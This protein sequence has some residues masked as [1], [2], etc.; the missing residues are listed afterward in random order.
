MTRCLRW[1][2]HCHRVP[3][4]T[5]PPPTYA[6]EQI[7]QTRSSTRDAGQR[8]PH[9]AD[10]TH[11]NREEKK[12]IRR[13]LRSTSEELWSNQQQK[14]PIRNEENQAKVSGNSMTLKKGLDTLHKKASYEKELI[15]DQTSS[16]Y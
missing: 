11:D 14:A 1:S 7:P 3:L 15:I 6:R 9:Q 12:R 5:D 10:P 8:D 13:L 4:R 16:C 2:Q